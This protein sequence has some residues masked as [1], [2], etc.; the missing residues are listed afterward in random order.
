MPVRI[1]LALPK[2]GHPARPLFNPDRRVVGQLHGGGSLCTTPTAPDQYGRIYTSWTGGGSA[3]T[4]LSDWL[5]PAGS[6]VTTTNS[7]KSQVSGPVTFVSTAAFSLNSGSSAITSWVVT[8]GNGMISPT[9]GSGNIA[10]LTATGS[11]S[12]ATITFSISAGQSYPIS[13]AKSFNADAGEN[14]PPSAANIPA[15][16]AV[17]G[18]PFSYTVPAFTDPEGLPLTYSAAGLPN[19]LSLNPATRVIAGTPTTS[20]TFVASIT[21][22]DQGGLETSVAFLVTVSCPAVFINTSA[23]IICQGQSVALTAGGATSYV[24]STGQTQAAIQATPAQTTTYSVTGITGS[25]SA[26][27]TRMITVQL[28]PTVSIN[29]TATSICQGQSV[30][31]TA[32]GATVY[33]WSSGQTQAGIQSAPTQTTTFSVT[34]T[35]NGC[36][37][38]ATRTI[39]VQPLPAIAINVNTGLICQGQSVVMTAIGATSYIWSTGQ[40]Q[41]TI[42]AT[43]AQTSIYSVT[44]TINGCSATTTRTITVQALPTLSINA[45]ALTICRGQ[46]VSLTANGANTYVWSTGEA[47]AGIQPAPAQTTTYSVTGTTNGCS[48]VTA[49]TVSVQAL[50]SLSITASTLTICQGQSVSLTANG[51]NAYLWSTGEARAG[52]QPA[53]AQ[54]TTYSVT[55]TTNGC[56]SVTAVTVS[57]QALPSLSITAS[58]LTICHWR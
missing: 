40:V 25:C 6:A 5:N 3:G 56:S 53:P 33:V 58:T 28:L 22:R 44:G 17:A 10:S 26:T 4:R 29:A 7:V 31:L 24:W 19:G 1:R 41:G 42:Q 37:A 36:S 27:A 39:S 46:S 57:V 20:G 30:G 21:A 2:A 18:T 35:A 15:Q 8:G 23:A 52:I 38:T 16:S 48:S 9:S 51:A 43:P 14:F 13:F 11:V 45:S 49:V 32:S 34:G 55:G 50:P 12:G 47:R 54:T